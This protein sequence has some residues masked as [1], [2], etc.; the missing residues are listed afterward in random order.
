[1]IVKQK[2]F[3][4]L[5]KIFLNLLT[6]FKFVNVD[7]K[8]IKI[9]LVSSDE[10]KDHLV[11]CVSG[12]MV[13]QV[14]LTFVN[15][16]IETNYILKKKIHNIR[17]TL[18]SSLIQ[19]YDNMFSGLTKQYLYNISIDD[20]NHIN[21]GLTLDYRLCY[22]I[23]SKTDKREV[24]DLHILMT[25]DHN[26]KGACGL[27]NLPT[28]DSVCEPLAWNRAAIDEIVI[29]YLINANNPELYNALFPTFD[30]NLDLNDIVDLLNCLKTLEMASY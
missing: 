25:R 11:I 6:Q 20:V 28:R 4:F 8:K 9:N 15:H 18:V 17:I 16:D 2:N 7:I 3:L 24:Q 19:N 5:K 26:I 10:Q 14:D 29:L 13:A 1:M 23:R 12:M 22:S 30:I 21:I 27:T